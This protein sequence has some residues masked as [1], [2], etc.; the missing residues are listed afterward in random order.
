MRAPSRSRRIAKWAGL[1]MC[2]VILAMWVASVARPS[3]LY[4]PYGGVWWAHG[5][6]AGPM[7]SPAS[8]SLRLVDLSLEWAPIVPRSPPWHEAVGLSRLPEYLNFWGMSALVV[9]FWLPLTLA[10]IPTVI[11]W[12]RDRRTVKPG[13]V[14][15]GYDLRASKKACPECGTA[16]AAEPR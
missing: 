16:I 5:V 6:L 9:P 2:V 3:I 14:N 8:N 1:V 4:T 7:S 12:L 10:A 13:C 11:L 15:C